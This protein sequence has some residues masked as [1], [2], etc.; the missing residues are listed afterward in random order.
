MLDRDVLNTLRE[1]IADE[2]KKRSNLNKYKKN[3]EKDH[4]KLILRQSRQRQRFF[5]YIYNH[6]YENAMK[7][8]REILEREQEV[9]ENAREILEEGRQLRIC[10]VGRDEDR[11]IETG[12][13]GF[14]KMA[15]NLK[16]EYDF[17]VMLC[18]LIKQ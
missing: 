10:M 3:H 17:R 2:V 12:E 14:L 15:D 11:K 13:G 7:I 9:L 18:G 5:S 1:T 16:Y 6:D 8:H 4:F